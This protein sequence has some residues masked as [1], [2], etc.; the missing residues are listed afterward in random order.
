MAE[1]ANRLP[2]PFQTMRFHEAIQSL[3]ASGNWFRSASHSTRAAK[4]LSRF[5]SRVV[6]PNYKPEAVFVTGDIATTGAMAD[7]RVAHDY[8]FPPT[9]GALWVDAAEQPALRLDAAMIQIMP[10]NHDRYWGVTLLPG[11][12]NFE[13]VFEGKWQPS[14]PSNRVANAKLVGTENDRVCVISADFSFRNA[15]EASGGIIDFVGQGLVS[16]DILNDLAASTRQSMIEYACPVIWNVHYPPAFP[17]C[18][19]NLSLRNEEILVQTARELGVQV[20]FA[21]HTHESKNYW[22]D[23]VL[24]SCVGSATE[25]SPSSSWH[26]NLV[27]LGV[28]GGMLEDLAIMPFV[29]ESHGRNNFSPNDEIV[30]EFD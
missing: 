24:V 14:G 9:A 3:G 25:A 17:D 1:G 30:F 20:I 29:Y 19:P 16:S 13:S 27:R 7:L 26:F 11:S 15:V 6:F 22:V 8:L 5:L 18:N 10:G 23:G 21:G 2:S 12:T 28:R 4:A